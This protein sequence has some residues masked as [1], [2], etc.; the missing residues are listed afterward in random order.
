MATDLRGLSISEGKRE[1]GVCREGSCWG[2]RSP[3]EPCL[4][5][6]VV[7]V[8]GH[9]IKGH[10]VSTWRKIRGQSSSPS[11]LQNS[12]ASQSTKLIKGLLHARPTSG[13]QT[14]QGTHT[15]WSIQP[16]QPNPTAPLPSPPFPSPLLPSPSSSLP[17]FL[18]SV[19]SFQ[20][21][22]QP[23]I[24]PDPVSVG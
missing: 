5:L 19:L 8:T 18:P 12:I 7:S 22:F 6:L 10:S 21:I 4:S 20:I 14:Q 13:C 11:P 23:Y 24:L 3:V 1:T 15:L 17:S 16:L 2:D 9:Q